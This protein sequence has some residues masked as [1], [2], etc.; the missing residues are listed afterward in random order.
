MRSSTVTKTALLV[1]LFI[2]I[3]AG[4]RMLYK[5]S[6]S[7][8][9]EI[10][11]APVSNSTKGSSTSPKAVPQSAAQKPAQ[12]E[13]NSLSGCS[14]KLQQETT[15]AKRQYEKGTILVTFKSDVSY[16]DAK[17]ILA[18]YGIAVQSEA[19]AQNTFKGRHLI[20]GAFTPG[21]EFIKTCLLRR[22]GRIAYAGLNII[23][24]LHE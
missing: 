3:V 18:T 17:D 8:D 11:N 21:E 4:G 20:T 5:P 15:A 23:F 24:T 19:S 1:G 9:L 16:D 12:D 14:T 13:D 2:V 10:N 7:S 22:D 6:R